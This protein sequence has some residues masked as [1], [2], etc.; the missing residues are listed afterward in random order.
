[1]LKLKWSAQSPSPINNRTTPTNLHYS[2]DSNSNSNQSPP[3]RVR[4]DEE[5][6]TDFPVSFSLTYL[7]ICC[8]MQTETDP[9]T[10]EEVVKRDRVIADYRR[11]VDELQSKVHFIICVNY[12]ILFSWMLKDG[13]TRLEESQLGS[14]LL[15]RTIWKEKRCWIGYRI[16]FCLYIMFLV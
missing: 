15:K 12:C 2:S 6:Q 8:I 11:Q 7:V 1:M 16:Y 13:V 9:L 10:M 4:V 5:T 3:G 14:C